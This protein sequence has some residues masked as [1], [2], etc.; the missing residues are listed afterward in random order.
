MVESWSILRKTNQEEKLGML[1]QIE[2]VLS[3]FIRSYSRRES[4]GRQNDPIDFVVTWVDGNDPAWQ[5][6]RSEILGI[7]EMNA[8]GNGVCRYRDWASF[9]YWFRAVRSMLHG[10]DMSIW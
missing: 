7:K 8:S 10:F 9:K 2:L 5:K 6:E 1:K 3:G 4:I